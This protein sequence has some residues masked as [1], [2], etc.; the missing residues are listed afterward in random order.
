M[1]WASTPLPLTLKVRCAGLASGMHRSLAF[2][3]T[4]VIRDSDNPTFHPVLLCT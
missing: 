4:A 1:H 2:I 3:S